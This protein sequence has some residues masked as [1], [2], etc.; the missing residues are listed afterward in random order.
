MSD[1]QTQSSEI[2][3]ETPWMKV[4]RNE[5]LNHNGKHLTYSFIELQHPSVFVVATNDKGEILLQ[6]SYRYVLNQTMWEVPAGYS[7]GETP[8]VSAK[9][10]LGEEAGLGG[11]NWI[12][13]GTFY[14]ANGIGNIP[15]TA[16]LVRNVHPLDTPL[17]KDEQITDRQF[18]SVAKI[19]KMIENGEIVE[20]AH[21]T[22]LYAAMLHNQKGEQ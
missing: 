14:Q 16:F 13:L 19:Q 1:W 9:C 5:V 7:D 17:D 11:D 21:I 3:Y 8:L 4:R 20:S 22:S 15:F 10:E 2:V 18:M 6:R 12:E